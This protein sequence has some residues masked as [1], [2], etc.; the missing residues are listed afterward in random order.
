MENQS[1]TRLTIESLAK[2]SL[3]L[4]TRIMAAGFLVYVGLAGV[5]MLH[6]SLS[7]RLLPGLESLSMLVYVVLSILVAQLIYT[8]YVHYVEKRTVDE[9]SGSNALLE[10]LAGLAIGG[11]LIALSLGILWL[12]GLYKIDGMNAWP[13]LYAPIHLQTSL[14]AGYVEELLFRGIIFRISE[15][16][17]GTWVAIG[18]QSVLFGFMHGW[19]PNSTV[20]GLIA[21]SLEAGILLGAAFALTRRLWLAIGIHTAWNYVQGAIFGVPVSGYDV[22]GLFISKPVGPE[23]LTGGAF[24]V[25]ASVLTLLI[26]TTAGLLML[27][28]AKQKGMLIDPFWVQT[29]VE[30]ES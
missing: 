8:L 3:F 2:I 9:F 18:I 10:L 7:D 17:L 5:A 12:F 29:S 16:K 23:L 30:G 21:I 20:F 13:V 22:Q 26:C 28:K 24:G 27:V 15:E 19:N 6:I 14:Y 4:L 25:E 11:G 1:G